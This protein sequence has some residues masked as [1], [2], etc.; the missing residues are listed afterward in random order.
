[1][2]HQNKM[3]SFFFHNLQ[4]KFAALTTSALIWYGVQ[5]EET[6]ELNK[7]AKVTITVPN[8]Y[9]IQGVN[10]C[11]EQPDVTSSIVCDKDVTLSGPRGLLAP[12][13]K[14][15]ANIQIPTTRNGQI[16]YLISKKY[17]QNLDR[18]VRMTIH[19]PYV[20]VYVDQEVKRTIPIQENLKGVPAEGY[21]ITEISITPSEVEV[22]GMESKLASTTHIE[23]N[24]IDISGLQKT[25]SFEAQLK[26]PLQLGFDT[27][28]VNLRVGD[29]KINRRFRSIP[30]EVE[31]TSPVIVR[32]RYASIIIQGT[33]GVL[34]FV[35]RSDLRA[36]IDIR[37]LPPGK[38]EKKIQIKIPP[39]T[40]LIET[41]PENAI[42][43]ILDES[44]VE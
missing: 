27:V 21:M 44:R 28:K 10:G 2:M 12:Q 8:G 38:H 32:P 14:L 17:F 16:R 1:M 22:T 26:S 39:D 25:A 35:R 7:R 29:R 33:P 11:R 31:T 24:L 36:F 23:T 15:T 5:G 20:V 9:L 41:T 3:T 19:D 40:V 34:S 6:L 43:E 30:I 42:V 4:Y 13:D 18:R 37:D